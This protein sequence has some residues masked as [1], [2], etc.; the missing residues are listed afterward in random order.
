MPVYDVGPGVILMMGMFLLGLVIFGLLKWQYV[1]QNEKNLEGEEYLNLQLNHNW[2]FWQDW[3]I[4]GERNVDRR[5]ELAD[6]LKA[7]Q[8]SKEDFKAAI[9]RLGR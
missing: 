8:I 6:Q 7:G 4:A 1:L 3:C 5:N 2:Q 9:Q